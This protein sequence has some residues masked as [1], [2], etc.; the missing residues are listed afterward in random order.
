MFPTQ[1]KT[2]YELVSSNMSQTFRSS[3]FTQQ[4][5]ALCGLPRIAS[6]VSKV[7]TSV[8]C[9]QSFQRHNHSQRSSRGTCCELI[10]KENTFAEISSRT[11]LNSSVVYCNDDHDGASF[12]S[13]PAWSPASWA[14]LQNK[15]VSSDDA[16][17]FSG[18]VSS[19][20][21]QLSSLSIPLIHV[22]DVRVPVVEGFHENSGAPQGTSPFASCGVE[23]KQS[24]K[25]LLLP[26]FRVQNLGP[27]NPQGDPNGK[28]EDF[29]TN[30]G[31][32]I[33][34]LRRELPMV[35]YE[36]LTYNIYRE[37]IVFTDPRNSFKGLD[38]YKLIFR[39]IRFFG[40]VFF[41]PRSL[42]LNII[43]IWQPNEGKI[44]VRWTVHGMPWLAFGNEEGTFD[45]T[46]EFK[47]DRNGKIYEH[48]VT[49][50]ALTPDNYM[51]VLSRML[52]M[53]VQT[54]SPTPSF[55]K[56]FQGWITSRLTKHLQETPAM[57][58]NE[59]FVAGWL[60]LRKSPRFT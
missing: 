20:V 46:S 13:D 27:P 43:R 60:Y 59:R 54:Q 55:F 16:A 3:Y 2:H 44:V 11:A 53:N 4:K 22:V 45:G 36:D 41:R 7:S 49:N 18:E 24:D 37:D 40:R 56:G 30:V 23:S 51:N 8:R 38:K 48:K 52:Q 15:A 34:T 32:A 57:N 50:V 1:Y 47:L 31:D 35:F 14:T 25:G 10:A 26:H 19:L 58:I 9:S 42:W 12:C 21:G 29:Y 33:R 39:T 28:S 5:V 17:L 6:P